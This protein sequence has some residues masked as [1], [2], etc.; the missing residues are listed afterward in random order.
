MRV[1]AF[2]ASLSVT[3]EE[4][5]GVTATGFPMTSLYVEDFP[6]LYTIGLYDSVH[7]SDTDHIFPLPVGMNTL[8]QDAGGA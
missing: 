2:A 1:V 8:M 5:G 6:A 7:S 3:D 4:A